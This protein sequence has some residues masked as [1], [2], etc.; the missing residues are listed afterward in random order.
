MARFEH[1]YAGL[2]Y[3]DGDKTAPWATFTP[4]ERMVDGREVRYGVLETDDTDVIKRLREMAERDEDLREIKTE[5]RK[6]TKGEK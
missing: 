6:S 4:A 1:R 5:A 2:I 3:Q